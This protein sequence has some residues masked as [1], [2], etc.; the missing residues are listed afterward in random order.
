M[1]NITEL[2]NMTDA[3]LVSTAESIGLKKIDI[4]QRENLI[5]EILDQQ[6]I[7]KATANAQRQPRKK[8][9][10]AAEA[11][12]NADA[13]NIAP[14]ADSAQPAEAAEQ[15]KKRGRK[16]KNVEAP[17]AEAPVAA[18]GA[19]TEPTTVAET[20]AQ[21]TAEAP[22]AEAQTEQPTTEKKRR[23]RPRKQD[24]AAAA[25]VVTDTET[26]SNDAQ[27]NQEDDEV[28]EAPLAEQ[29]AAEQP[30]QTKVFTHAKK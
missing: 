12:N 23:G 26:I 30:Q 8:R 6:A 7:D 28:P 4:A 5:Y 18:E 11:V 9:A 19:A 24:V 2:E 22:A 20:S 1:Y 21:P 15:P 17:S 3:D 14:A 13:T 10:K 27:A 16:K 25:N 29:E